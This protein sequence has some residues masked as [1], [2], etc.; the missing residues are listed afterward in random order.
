M[1]KYSISS[2]LSWMSFSLF[3]FT[4]LSLSIS[5][6]IAQSNSNDV[7]AQEV[8]QALNEEIKIKLNAQA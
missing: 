1:K 7:V 5:E 8:K 3:L 6:W 4:V 2:K